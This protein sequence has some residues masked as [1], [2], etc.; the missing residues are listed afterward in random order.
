MKEK[1]VFVWIKSSDGDSKE[2]V[3]EEIN[4][5]AKLSKHKELFAPVTPPLITEHGVG[6]IQPQSSSGSFDQYLQ[7]V[8]DE[9]EATSKLPFLNEASLL[10]LFES[11]V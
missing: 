9:A 10:I 2:R 4:L 5:L 7:V 8:R 11:M 1:L 3:T 6:V